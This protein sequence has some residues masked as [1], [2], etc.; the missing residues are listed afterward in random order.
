MCSQSV[1]KLSE[2]I[3]MFVMVYYVREMTMKKS[4]KYGDY[5]S[6]EQLLFF[7]YHYCHKNCY[8]CCDHRYFR[9]L[10]QT[11]NNSFNG[12]IILK[13]LPRKLVAVLLKTGLY[14]V[15]FSCFKYTSVTLQETLDGLTDN[16]D[17]KTVLS[18]ICG[19]Y[20]E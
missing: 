3:E 14:K 18:Y 7:Y 1:S 4:C 15:I 5:G 8:F 17:L 11:A 10:F 20:G 13:V 9:Y 2:A 12:I 6:F 19:D 16:K